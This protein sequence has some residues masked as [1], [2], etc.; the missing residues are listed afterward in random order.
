MAKKFLSDIELEAGL[1]DV[2]GNTGTSGQILSS[3]GT[4]VDWVDA[5]D[6]SAGSAENVEILVKNTSGSTLSK[7][8][9][10]YIIGS[11]AASPR[12]E[13]GLADAGNASHMPAA[14]LLAQ[15]LVNNAEGVAVV[16]GKLRNLATDPIDGVTPS[17]NDTLYVK[18][19]GGLT[20]TKPTGSTNLI[21]NV[22]QVGRV[23]SSADGNIVCSAILRSN[24]VPNLSTGRIWVGEGNT[25]E[26]TVVYIDETNNEFGINTASPGA[27]L[28][29]NGD[30]ALKGDKAFQFTSPT[31]KI[32]DIDGGGAIT[33][34]DLIVDGTEAIQIE[35]SAEIYIAS[36][37]G[38]IGDQN[39]YFEFPSA[40]TI[41]FTT[42]ASERMRVIS[43]GYVAI[44]QTT[45][46]EKLHVNGTIKAETGFKYEYSGTDTFQ[47]TSIFG[48]PYIMVNSGDTLN[49]GGGPG[50]IVNNLQVGSGSVTADIFYTDDK[51][52]HAGDTDTYFSFPTSN[53]ASIVTNGSTRLYVESDGDIGVGT[54]TPQ[55]AFH[56]SGSGNKRLE[57][58]S[59]TT[60]TVGLK[61][62]NTSS[63]YAWFISGTD[64]KYKLYDY[65]AGQIILEFEPTTGKAVFIHDVEANN[66]IGQKTYINWRGFMSGTSLYTLYNVGLTTAFPYAYGTINPPYDGY[67]SRV[68]MTNNAYSSYSSGP[69]GTSVTLYVYKNGTLLTSDTQTYTTS[70]PD[71]QV[72]F[73]FGTNAIYSAGDKIALRVQSNGAWYYIA[74]GIELTER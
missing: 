23:S 70:T 72:V 13:V 65:T 9:P 33:F 66:F 1:V 42:G 58:E 53:V 64:G 16:V 4:A 12:L 29:V 24:D 43:N 62:T 44:G 32:G 37:I 63:S 61:T 3:T 47:I 48:S 49:I 20:T 38:H 36:R 60:G 59:T 18:S 22:G 6:I 35:D 26:S 8:D 17:E 74:W 73:D 51:L 40:D 14:G 54:T 5:A 27:A 15:D 2:N 21:Q 31:L 25:I 7:G 52:V 71:V 46:D 39:T 34:I 19:G 68:T 56:I 67:V 57:V 28:D 45:A 55:E 11:V 50:S 30:I 69:A 41:T 10:V